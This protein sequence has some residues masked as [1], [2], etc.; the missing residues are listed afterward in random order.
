[1]DSAPAKSDFLSRRYVLQPKIVMDLQQSDSF[2]RE[3]A[4]SPKIAALAAA[5]TLL[6]F[7]R[8]LLISSDGAVIAA[9]GSGVIATSAENDRKQRPPG[10]GF[11]RRG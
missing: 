2:G 9:F 7:L 4:K 6:G 3:T 5:F 10:G 8:L 1:V 11:W